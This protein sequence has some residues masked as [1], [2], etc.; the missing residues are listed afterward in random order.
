MMQIPTM[1]E[2]MSENETSVLGQLVQ[3]WQEKLTRN[4]LRSRYYEGHNTLKD[5]GISIP[6]TLKDTE[7]VVGWPAK[8]VDSLTSR[9]MFD[10]F[11]LPGSEGDPLGLRPV[12][13]ANQF[14]F[15]YQQAVRS[16]L[17]HSVAFWTVSYGDRTAGEPE[18]VVS[19][20]S[21]EFASALWDTRRRRIRAGL[22][23]T[24]VESTISGAVPSQVTLYLDAVT[25]IC[26]REGSAW[27]VAQR[28]EHNLGRPLMEPMMFESSD[29]R[30]FG[31]SRITREV[32]SITDSA[33][34]QALRTE[35]LMEANTGPQKALLGADDEAFDM[36]RWRAYMTSLLAI[37]KDEDGETPTL[38]Q[39]P[40]L[41]PQGAI[42]YMQ[43]LAGRFSGATGVPVST[44]GVVQDNPSSAQALRETRDDLIITAQALNRGNRVAL[45]NVARLIV[46]VRDN[47][48]WMDLP[49]EA[50]AVHANFRSPAMPSIVS[51]S[52]AMVKQ[53]SAIPWLAETE[54]ALEELGYDESQITRLLDAKRRSEGKGLVSALLEA[55]KPVA[56]KGG[57]DVEPAE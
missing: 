3:V 51:Q 8:A 41:T 43:H 31:R 13:A 7:T 22:A 10:G 19:F 1:I 57:A 9:S 42:T 40:Q 56:V 21:A 39:L 12:L 35:V 52:D 17:I 53:I 54:V 37:S 23:V 49:A 32:M 46:A 5:L 48:A 30:P 29:T 15:A 16:E 26:E 36:D 50:W 33:Q 45:D 28:V 14:D 38:M 18:V 2:G 6:P 47:L 27:S 11:V 25:I 20:R 24:D 4:Q 34:R 55:R 44:L